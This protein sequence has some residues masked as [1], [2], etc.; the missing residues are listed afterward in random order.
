MLAR[1]RDRGPDGSQESGSLAGSPTYMTGVQPIGPFS[2][3]FPGALAESWTESTV[4][5]TQAS[6]MIWDAG[7]ESGSL[8]CCTTTMTSKV[9]C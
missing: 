3:A 9:L 8:T 2:V 1:A 6:Y 7:T 4:S 5:E